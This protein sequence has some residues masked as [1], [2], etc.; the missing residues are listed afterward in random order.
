MTLFA[1]IHRDQKL[2]LGYPE[3]MLCHKHTRVGL[4]VRTPDPGGSD[5]AVFIESG[6]LYRNK[7][8]NK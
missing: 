3:M 1:T 7:H 2:G 4:H 6:D 8:K 5:P